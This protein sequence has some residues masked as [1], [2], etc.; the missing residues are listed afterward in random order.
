MSLYRILES[1]PLHRL[2]GLPV[3]VSPKRILYTK[4]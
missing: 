4:H 2:L 1:P 3:L